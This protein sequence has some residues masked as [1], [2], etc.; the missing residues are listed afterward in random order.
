VSAIEESK[1]QLLKW[2]KDATRSVAELSDAC[3]RFPEVDRAIASHPSASGELLAKLSHS[4]DKATRA[5]VAANP[6]APPADLV[7]LAQQFPKEFLENPALDLLLLENPALLEEAPVSLLVRLLKSDRC[8]ADFLIWAATR[9]EEKVQMAVV[10]TAAAPPQALQVLGQSRHEKVRQGVQARTVGSSQDI[11]DPEDGFRQEVANRMRSMK[12]SELLE[13][14]NAKDIG[15][16]QWPLLPLLLRLDLAGALSTMASCSDATVLEHL[17]RGGE[18]WLRE[19]VVKNPHAPGY[20]SDLLWR[21]QVGTP[22]VSAPGDSLGL[23]Y[24]S[25]NARIAGDSSTP[26]HELTALSKDPL[27]VVRWLV[28]RNPK[29]P[30]LVLDDLS[31]DFD[32]GVR[33]AAAENRSIPSPALEVLSKDSDAEVR[34]AVAGNPRTAAQ[35]L[36]KLAGDSEDT[37]RWEISGNP[38]A[39]PDV[40]EVLSKESEWSVRL[41]IARNPGTPRKLRDQLLDALS[42]ETEW[43]KRSVLADGQDDTKILETLARDP[44]GSVRR[45]VAENPI[46]PLLSLEALAKDPEDSVRQAV[47]GNPSASARVLNV[48][49][50]HSD[51]GFRCHLV[52]GPGTRAEVLKALAKDS[53]KLVRRRVAEN[54]SVPAKVFE[55]LAKDSEELVRVAVAKNPSTPVK[56]LEA[57]AQ[58]SE[59]WVRVAVANNPSTPVKVL[60]G[61]AQ[62]SEGSVRRAVAENPSTPML[63]LEALALDSHELVRSAVA[64]NSGTPALVLEALANDP[65]EFVRQSVGRN[66]KSPQSLLQALAKDTCESVR[67]QVAWNSNILTPVLEQLSKD[68]S[69]KVRLAVAGKSNAAPQVLEAM[70][71]DTLLVRLEL[72]G[73]PSTP[74]AALRKLAASSEVQ[75]LK[76]VVVHKA[77]ADSLLA[78]MIDDGQEEQV[79]ASM[80]LNP[81]IAPE[82]AG[83]VARIL[84]SDVKPLASGYYKQQLTAAVPSMRHACAVGDTL[85]F[86]GKDPNKTV[87][88]K[89]PMA[90]LMA[91][92]AG[93]FIEP[94]RIAR[95]AGSTDWLIRAAVARNMGTPEGLLKK[96]SSDAHPLVSTLAKTRSGGAA[97]R[98]LAPEQ[99]A[100]SSV[101]DLSRAASEVFQRLR[102]DEKLSFIFTDCAWCDQGSVADLLRS[103]GECDKW[104]AMTSQALD[105]VLADLCQIERDAFLLKCTEAPSEVLRGVVA[106]RADCPVAILRRLAK[107]K[108][109][110]V[111]EV[112]IRRLPAEE[113]ARVIPRIAARSGTEIEELSRL[114]VNVDLLRALSVSKSLFVRK[115][116]AGNASSPPQVLE[117]LLSDPEVRDELAKNPNT[118]PRF[119]VCKRNDSELRRWVAENSDAPSDLLEAL[120]TDHDESVWSRTM[121]NPS[122]RA[123]VI[124]YLSDRPYLFHV[125]PLELLRALSRNSDEEVRSAVACA[126]HAPTAVLEALWN[127]PDAGVRSCV[128]RNPRTPPQSIET[129]STD[130]DAGVRCSVARNPKTPPQVLEAM[131]KD[132]DQRVLAWV[133]NNPST[134]RTS[135]KA[136]SRS[137]N[138]ISPLSLAEDAATPAAVLRELAVD[139]DKEVRLAVASNPGT[140]SDLLA[141][142]A[143]DAD[144]DIRRL[145]ALNPFTPPAQIEKYLSNWVSAIRTAIHRERVDAPKGSGV[146]AFTV[147]LFDLTRGLEWLSLFDYQPDNKALT[148]ASRSK[149]WLTRLA[150]ALHPKATEGILGLL[151]QDTD[152]DVACAAMLPRSAVQEA[153]RR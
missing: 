112:V 90:A 108:S 74:A 137:P 128:A 89:R 52:E 28:A 143:D 149:D 150:A 23:A 82:L 48:V 30:P 132:A 142:L 47:A 109:A 70:A 110:Q 55:A 126:R 91:L 67:L 76:K 102:K 117:N 6:A 26:P 123:V 16:P 130:P 84:L 73:N 10:M 88:A 18:A 3:G 15:L 49:A 93:P 34:R 77:A 75:I 86:G 131:S 103:L 40:L 5:R 14:W 72:A 1:A 54:P 66:L 116:V 140:P 8:P 104:G 59:G 99:S 31:E 44:E 121:Q 148:K 9:P 147:G 11:S 85:H 61:L 32:S 35:V 152:S 145:A 41:T 13:A 120:L 80:L 92:C 78:L 87:L 119:F 43:S 146:R 51:W 33:Q 153:V 136:L 111:L 96:L 133:A 60:E 17:F 97:A 27:D 46:T 95:V 124:K 45:A 50:M 98:V 69:S 25:D 134:P 144:S 64:S 21:N 42:K 125:L 57:L 139:R 63:I 4:K 127:D 68:S 83:R 36:H 29:T 106:E 115:G 113:L 79:L 129:L 105:L 100:T 138:P 81:A 53:E 2:A 39:P 7:R 151:A 22:N 37:V 71:N 141:V 122:A 65:H 114:T 107:D 19:K 101:M 118:S 94:S 12:S 135:M 58:D 20:L 38:S 56:V 24:F 62:D